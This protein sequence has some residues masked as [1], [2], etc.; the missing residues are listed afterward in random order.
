VVVGLLAACAGTRPNAGFAPRPEQVDA[1]RRCQGGSPPACSALGR[2]LTENRDNGRDFERGLVLLEIACGQDDLPACSF[3]AGLYVRESRGKPS[4]ARAHDLAAH[5][6]GLRFGAACTQLGEVIRYQ[7]GDQRTMVE[8]F[9]KGCALGDAEGC[10]L[11]GV[12]QEDKGATADG[13]G[14]DAALARACE[15]GRLSGCHHLAR[16]R[17]RQPETRPEAAALMLRSCQG[18]H[19]AS[20]EYITIWLAPLISANADC[21]RVAPLADTACRAKR[22]SACAVSDVCKLAI[23]HEAGPALERLRAACDHGEALACLYW[24]DA[25]SVRTQPKP[26][27]ESLFQAYGV[28]CRIERGPLAE[29]ACPRQAG[30]KLARARGR[31][32]ADTAL[33]DLQRT[34]DS[35]MG[36]ACCELGEQYRI[37]RWVPADAEKARELRS[38]A[39]GLGCERCCR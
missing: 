31:P 8:A 38:K 17:F 20:C 10:E 36:E 23:P 37:G 2:M 25:E 5:A 13:N 35:S 18:G 28:G 19:A 3:L 9:E 16:K 22:G 29:V 6:C 14:V 30:V 21:T 33:S 12:A 1:E 7:D 26:D 4:L 32:E 34:C 27:L 15:L 24:A 39:C 11:Y